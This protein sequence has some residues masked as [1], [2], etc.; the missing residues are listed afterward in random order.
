[1]WQDIVITIASIGFSV[2]LIPQVISGFKT[3]RKTINFSTALITFIGI[4]AMAVSFLTLGLYFSATMNFISGTLWFLLFIQ[5][6]VY[7][8]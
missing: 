1:M 3:K 7:K 6:I 5:S 2:A 4:Y 8:K